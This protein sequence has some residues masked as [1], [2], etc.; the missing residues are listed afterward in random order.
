MAPFAEGMP[1]PQD[2]RSVAALREAVQAGLVPDYRF[3]WSSFVNV[4]GSIGE[5]CMSQW[6][7]AGF[8]IGGVNYRTAEHFMMA[9]K[10]RLFGDELALAKI[11]R[12]RFPA[13]VKRF[14]RE[15]R[16]FDSVRWE[17]QR[18]EIVVQGNL[19]KFSQNAALGDYLLGT[20]ESV[21][22]EASPA[23]AIWGIGL[24]EEHPYAAQPARW[25]GLNLLG[26]ALMEVRARLC[27]AQSTL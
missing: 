8:E 5:T 2:L 25:P 13:E 24:A 23:D 16:K 11:L 1:S 6:Y 26:F 4:D 3:F 10:A 17:Q 20:G 15:V 14:G 21:L 18:F 22:V 27:A 9:G 12:S 19:A 7:P